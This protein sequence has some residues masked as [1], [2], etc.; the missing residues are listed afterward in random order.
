MEGTYLKASLMQVIRSFMILELDVVSLSDLLPC[1]YINCDVQCQWNKT[2]AHT[3][4]HFGSMFLC[5]ILTCSFDM[6]QSGQFC[7][8]KYDGILPPINVLWQKEVL[9]YQIST[10][11]VAFI[12]QVFW[13]TCWHFSPFLFCL[14]PW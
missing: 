7:P 4:L 1:S 11:L 6:L 9:L 10:T 14:Y 3:L 2:I 12:I 5:C 13:K 8:Y